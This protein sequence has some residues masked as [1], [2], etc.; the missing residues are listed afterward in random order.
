[1]TGN[2]PGMTVTPRHREAEARFR[3]LLEAGE[4]PGPDE[5][6]YEPESVVFYWNEPKLAVVVDFEEPGSSSSSRADH[7][8]R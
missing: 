7:A 2:V 8:P 5:V 6:G 3:E 1:M 4:L